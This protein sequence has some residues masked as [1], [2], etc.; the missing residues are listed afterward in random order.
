MNIPI[1]Y[2]DEAGNTG[3]ALLDNQ[4][5][6]FVVASVDYLDEEC[7]ELLPIVKSAQGAEAKFSSLRKSDRGCQRLLDFFKSPLHSEKRAKS[8]VILK[9]YMVVTK[10]VDIIEETLAHADGLDIY[11]R[12]ANIAT[13]N[14]HFYLSPLFCGRERYERFLSSFVEMIRTK[15][16]FAISQFFEC[17]NDM[18]S[19]C[20]EKDY[21]SS[22]APYL[23]AESFIDDILNGIDFLALDPAIPAFFLHCTE[24]GD[25]LNAEFIA[26]HD[27]SKPLTAVRSTFEAM[28]DK[29]IPEARIGYDRRKFG[30]PL[31]ARELRFGDS[32]NYPA[33]QVADLFA[34]AIAYHAS[35]IALGKTDKLSNQLGD[36]GIER[37]MFNAIWP[38]PKVTPEELGTSEVGGIHSTDY[39]AWA[40]LQKSM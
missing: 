19:N 9:Q 36:V 22:F 25:Q 5:P 30:L 15:S 1:I 13:S 31:K 20:S 4:Q 40:L 35:S 28:M 7:A 21:K 33:L 2:F 37:F 39:M 12:G 23:Y 11:K 6:V 16:R 29:T 17:A 32:L 14:M 24:W 26:L 38:T 8:V 18:Y 3:A 27:N 10:L 34:G